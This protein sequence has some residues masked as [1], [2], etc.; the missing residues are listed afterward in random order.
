MARHAPAFPEDVEL[1]L[2]E[3]ARECYL[4]GGRDRLTTEEDDAVFVVGALDGGERGVVDGPGEIHS[5]DLGAD[6]G[7]GGNDFHASHDSPRH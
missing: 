1:D 3:A 5:I 6:R 2:A 4:V 7:R